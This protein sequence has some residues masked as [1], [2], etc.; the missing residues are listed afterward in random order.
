MECV[1]R[2]LNIDEVAGVAGACL[3]GDPNSLSPAQRE[4][5]LGR[6]MRFRD[7]RRGT[8]PAL[9]T[10]DLPEWLMSLSTSRREAPSGR[11]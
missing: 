2:D 1:L 11:F 10:D 9:S 3:V 8:G 4:I 6:L 7:A 5:L